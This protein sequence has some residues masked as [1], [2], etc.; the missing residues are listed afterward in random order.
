M[1]PLSASRF[2]VSI[3]TFDNQ[4]D[5]LL[6]TNGT[7]VQAGLV[8]GL[9]PRWESETFVIASTTPEPFSQVLG[10]IGFSYALMGPVYEGSGEVPPYATMYL[11]FGF[12]GE[13][14]AS[15]NYGPY[16][17]LTPLS[18]GGPQFRLRERT[19]TFGAYY[20]IPQQSVTLFWN[21]FQLDFYVSQKLR[22]AGA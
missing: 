8:A 1:F 17:K 13:P 15:S 2:A 10:G 11:G 9:S 20:N 4:H 21:L 3:G 19:L 14:G 5:S 12:M 6:F 22:S 7:H 16:I 18:V